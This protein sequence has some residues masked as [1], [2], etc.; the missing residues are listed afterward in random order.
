M[1]GLM[2]YGDYIYSLYRIPNAL[3]QPN[4]DLVLF[5]QC[6]PAPILSCQATVLHATKQQRAGGGVIWC[7]RLNC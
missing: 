6:S 5:L 4:V 1:A 2:Q 3:A 7:Q